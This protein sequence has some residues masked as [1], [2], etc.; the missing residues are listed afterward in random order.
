MSYKSLSFSPCFP[1]KSL[2]ALLFSPA[3]GTCL[4]QLILHKSW[5]SSVCCFIQFPLSSSPF[6]PSISAAH[7][8][9]FS[10]ECDAATEKTGNIKIVVSNIKVMVSNIKMIVSN[11]KVMV[12]NIKMIVS[13]IK[14]VVSNI[15]VMVSNIKMMVSNIKVMVSN[16]QWLG[17]GCSDKRP[18]LTCG[19]G[20]LLGSFFLG[21]GITLES[22]EKLPPCHRNIT[23]LNASWVCNW[24]STSHQIPSILCKLKKM[25]NVQMIRNGFLKW[26]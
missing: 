16:S 22:E 18:W 3:C 1:T 14:I 9:M 26:N 6:Q 8:V 25:A 13:N 2:H 24:D 20:L 17:K 7:W 4:V 12:S 11:I 15:T 23:Q 5:S 19:L 10:P 21:T